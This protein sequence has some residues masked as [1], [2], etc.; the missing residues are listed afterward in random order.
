MSH[1]RSA[2]DV[3]ADALKVRQLRDLLGIEP[4]A[5]LQQLVDRGQIRPD[6]AHRDEILELIKAQTAI[7]V[8]VGVRIPKNRVSSWPDSYDSS[9]GYHW[10]LQ[11]N[12]LRDG[13]GRTDA[14][15]VYLNRASELILR[16]LGYPEGPEEFN[17]LGLA[18]GQVQ[19]GKTQNFT[20]VTAKAFDA[21]YR[22]VVVLSGM[23]DDLRNQTQ[24]RL[25]RDLGSY[26]LPG[27]GVPDAENMIHWETGLDAD[28]DPGSGKG[29]HLSEGGKHVFVVKKQKDRLQKLIGFLDGNVSAGTPLLVIDDESDHASVD[30]GTREASTISGLVTDLVE[31]AGRVS[32]IGYTATPAA[33]VLTDKA[34]AWSL[35]PR[36]FINVLPEPETP[37]YTGATAMFGPEALISREGW[38][39]KVGE[40]EAHS[41]NIPLHGVSTGLR[42]A[43][44]AFFLASACWI[45][46]A[47]TDNVPCTMLVHT[48]HLTVDH[49]TVLNKLSTLVGEIQTG[50]ETRREETEEMFRQ[51]WDT[52]LG[53]GWQAYEHSSDAPHFDRVVPSLDS[54]IR[55]FSIENDLLRINS[56]PGA[57]ELDFAATPDLKAI[58]TGGNKLSRG[59]T[60]EGLLVSYFV[61]TAGAQDTLHQ[62][63]RWFGFRGKY[64]DLTR[65]YTTE[66]LCDE[67]EIIAAQDEE[68]RAYFLRMGHDPEIKPDD[69]P[70]MLKVSPLTRLT[71]TGPAKMRHAN[72]ERFTWSGMDEITQY[73][74]FN[75]GEANLTATR[76]FLQG[77]GEPGSVT[78][79]HLPDGLPTWSTDDPESIRRFLED[80]Q[81][82]S[83]DYHQHHLVD[84]IRKQND[85]DELTTWFVVVAGLQNKDPRLSD[86]DLHI[87]GG[88]FPLV[89]TV[90][91]TRQVRNPDALGGVWSAGGDPHE[92]WGLTDEQYREAE[93]LHD[94][95]GRGFSL[96]RACR[97]MRDPAEALLVI[98]P[99]SRYSAPALDTKE[100]ETQL[101]VSDDPD[102]GSDLIA[103]ALSF[104]HSSSDAIFDVVTTGNVRST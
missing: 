33:P 56:V 21:G 58:I 23:T 79:R 20:A 7:H 40:A 5:A 101:P 87:T 47:E 62:M 4:E 15:L 52:D 30:T 99:V 36:D 67:F 48:A 84:Y 86:L 49:Q 102:H 39:R 91:R 78:G 22:V 16:D 43:V 3:S 94:D 14:E 37:P 69:I 8:R 65:V 77:L 34:T 66:D 6:P 38:F 63:E 25:M 9:R 90:K 93:K 88:G 60:V 10:V 64:L 46:R 50:W 51:L 80:F 73:L 103:L 44:R 71:V 45:H 17:I 72:L 92:A 19:S 53:P 85:E 57:G 68:W 41:I 31:T 97:Y 89:H 28:F 27:V 76:E 70:P 13:L 75:A 104:P 98:Y 24:R 61:R 18:I 29:T 74:P 42:A 35:F 82:D 96:V 100:V 95:H 12:F 26:D 59:I 54:F 1:G 83:R 32:Y 11:R 81:V 2:G 55:N